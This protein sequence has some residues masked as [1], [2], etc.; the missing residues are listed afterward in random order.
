VIVPAIE[1]AAA[2]T[3]PSGLAAVVGCRARA[4]ATRATLEDFL[5]GRGALPRLEP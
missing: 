1:R 2:L 5:G 3:S 4:A